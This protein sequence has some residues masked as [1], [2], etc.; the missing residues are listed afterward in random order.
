[1]PSICGLH[2]LKVP[3]A[4]VETSRDW[5]AEVFGFVPTLDFEEEDELLGVVLEHP[6]GVAVF[7]YRDPD[8]AEALRGFDLMGFGVARRDELVAWENDLDARG[9][10]HTPIHEAHLGEAIGVITPEGLVVRLNTREQ[11]ST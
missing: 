10:D 3:V 6:S 8:R 2:H 7:V 4:D 1:M 9:V 11:P 5:Y